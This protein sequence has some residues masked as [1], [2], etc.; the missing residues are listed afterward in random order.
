MM[1]SGGG[2]CP[3]GKCPRFAE[4]RVG[5]GR[6]SSHRPWF[7]FAAAQTSFRATVLSLAR[8]TSL[9][10]TCRRFSSELG[11]VTLVC[12]SALLDVVTN[13]TCWFTVCAEPPA[14]HRMCGGGLRIST[15]PSISA[16]VRECVYG[17]ASGGILRPVYR[18]ILQF[19]RKFTS[20]ALQNV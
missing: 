10:R 16:C 2:R 14:A 7:A 18:R 19:C 15:C 1:T 8:R 6:S 4:T 12:S 13:T 17:H 11:S 5:G 9:P 3:G 20:Y